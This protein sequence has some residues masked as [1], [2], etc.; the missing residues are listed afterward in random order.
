MNEALDDISTE[1]YGSSSIS[2]LSWD[3]RFP[4]EADIVSQNIRDM[5]MLSNSHQSELIVI[6]QMT[7]TSDHSIS[8]ASDSNDSIIDIKLNANLSPL[9]LYPSFTAGIQLDSSGYDEDLTQVKYMQKI[10]ENENSG[11]DLSKDD[12][13]NNLNM[14]SSTQVSRGEMNKSIVNSQSCTRSGLIYK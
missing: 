1:P 6:D 3:P 11:I 2:S 13:N 12:S 7:Q 5:A 14:S 8:I 9:D 4:I 10:D